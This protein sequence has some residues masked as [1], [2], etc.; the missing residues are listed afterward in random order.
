MAA[1]STFGGKNIKGETPFPWIYLQGKSFFFFAFVFFSPP[2][3]FEVV[4]KRDY[5]QGI[6]NE[7]ALVAMVGVI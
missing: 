4:K 3:F 1:I 6:L 2:C 5:P 7:I